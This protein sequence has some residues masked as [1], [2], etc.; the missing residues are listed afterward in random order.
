MLRCMKAEHRLIAGICV[1]AALSSMLLIRLNHSGA[2]PAG[3]HCN[4]RTA[5]RP[6]I[7]A[8]HGGEDGGA[9][10]LSGMYESTLNL[11]ISQK[12]QLIFALFGIDPVMT[13]ESDTI[14][15]P[16][17]AATV[18]Q[19]KVADQKA[20]VALINSVSDAYLLSIHQNYYPSAGPF[21]AQTLYAPTDE[22]REFALFLQD[23]LVT[24][25]NPDNYRSASQIS[26]DIYL[27]NQVRCP[28]VLIECGFLSNPAEEALLKTECYRLKL[29]VLITAGFLRFHAQANPV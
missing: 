22:S 7:D 3:V 11:D 6:V 2:V 4:G 10:S 1:I 29:A 5:Y 25:L 9:V 15:Y 28:A 8:G 14:A 27:M 16:E 12:I 21:G 17:D 26:G 24:G 18:R 23:Q 20:R 19:R 13:R